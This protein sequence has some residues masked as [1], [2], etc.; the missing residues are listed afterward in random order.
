MQDRTVFL[1]MKCQYYSRF[2]KGIGG[3]KLQKAVVIGENVTDLGFRSNFRAALTLAYRSKV[4]V[5]YSE[6]GFI[7]QDACNTSFLNT[8]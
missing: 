2:L 4:T 5:K 1:S 7:D 6:S 8:H 3:L